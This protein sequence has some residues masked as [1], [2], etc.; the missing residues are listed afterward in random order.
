MVT[1]EDSLL[2]A[3]V[4]AGPALGYEE[5]QRTTVEA[6]VEEVEGATEGNLESSSIATRRNLTG[7][8]VVVVEVRERGGGGGGGAGPF[9]VTCGVTALVVDEEV[10]V[11]LG[12][13]GGGGGGGTTR[14]LNSCSLVTFAVLAAVILSSFN[15]RA[16]SSTSF[17]SNT[18]S[19]SFFVRLSIVRFAI[20]SA[21]K[22][23]STSLDPLMEET[24]WACTETFD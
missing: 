2:E 3:E 8:E 12:L 6:V 20:S 11:R 4:V 22:S 23:D 5:W 1:G 9:P 14:L 24:F 15:R 19:S 7:A 21:S 17:V 13:S 18:I 10:L 16:S